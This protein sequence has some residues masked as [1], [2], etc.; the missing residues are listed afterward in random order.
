ML[1]IQAFA[2]GA[3]IQ[4]AVILGL[5]LAERV[6][7]ATYAQQKRFAENIAIGSL[8]LASQILGTLCLAPI[9][10]FAINR[11]GGGLWVLPATGTGVLFSIAIYV[12]AMDLGE[13][14]FHR[15]QHRI[16]FLWAMH[17]LHHSDVSFGATTAVRH[18]W[19]ESW[20][21]GVTVWLAVGILIK[22]PSAALVTYS[23]LGLYNFVSHSNLP[24]DFG[25]ASWLWNSPAYH[26]LHHSRL[27]E[28]DGYNYAALLPIFD[29][30]SGAY[31]RPAAGHYPA[32][33]M[34]DGR[35]LRTALQIVFWPLMARS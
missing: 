21:K 16:P 29:W 27:P 11:A 30:I 15:A 8:G 25:Y 33:G 22:A 1:A 6:R 4:L 14:L 3:L 19:L 18:F 7:P 2:A 24:L 13:Y 23:A 5:A 31:L 17:S 10:V 35:T 26:R 34:S 32:T 20:L 12:T 9:S 28:H